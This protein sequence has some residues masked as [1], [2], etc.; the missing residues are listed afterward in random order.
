MKKCFSIIVVVLLVM[1]GVS[2]N[3]NKQTPKDAAMDFR[4]KLTA[5]D[6]T[7]MLKLCDTAMEQ[8]KQKHIDEVLA[9]LYEYTDSSKEVK[10]LSP[11][12]EKSYRRRFAMFPVLEYERVYFTFKSA[13]CNDVK[14]EVVF[15][16]AEQTY[17]EEPAKIAYV[18]NPIKIDG[19]W[20]LCVKTPETR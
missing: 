9:S 5:N 8:L 12:T 10:K 18:F 17:L 14:Y 3:D 16:T 6:T 4:S 2:C 7:T 11:D 13:E 1:A 20:K 15:R 19:E